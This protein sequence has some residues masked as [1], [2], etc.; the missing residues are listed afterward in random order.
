MDKLIKKYLLDKEN[1]TDNNL[2]NIIMEYF[3]KMT[4]TESGIGI[5]TGSKYFNKEWRILWLSFDYM[6]GYG[7]NNVIDFTKY[8]DNEIIGIFGNNA[9]GKSSLID[10]ITF[11]LYHKTC[12]EDTLKDIININSNKSIGVIVFEAN[13]QKYMIQKECYRDNKKKNI[14]SGQQIKVEMTM[15]KLNQTDDQNMFHLHGKY[16]KLYSLTEKDR[17]KTTEALETLIGDL[18]NFI[19]TSV[20]LQGNHGTFKSKDNK[21]KKE[22]LCRV[23]NI[24]HFSN[25]EKDIIDHYKKIKTQMAICKRTQ[26]NITNMSTQEI[27][28]KINTL[29]NQ[30]IPIINEEINS[31]NELITNMEKQ[32][33]D[34]QTELIKIESSIIIKNMSDLDKTYNNILILEQQLSD[35]IRQKHLYEQQLYDL[36]IS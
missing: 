10:I 3:K 11:L 4:N 1:I 16:Y 5:N 21:Q 35:I 15:Y 27:N 26:E 14:T 36:K 6:F 22:Y 13:K 23:L 9:I 17:Y 29:Q 34:S 32:I 7:P 25:C 12:R 8:P 18:Q 19:L 2:M 28:D 20:L 30:I 24:D 33:Y 31:N